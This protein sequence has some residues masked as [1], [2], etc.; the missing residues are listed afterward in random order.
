GSWLCD[1]TRRTL[2]YVTGTNGNNSQSYFTN[3]YRDYVNKTDNTPQIRYAEVLLTLAE[4][5]ARNASG[6][7]QRAIDLLNTVRNRALSAPATQQY[8]ASN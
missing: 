4:A 3:K 6:V 5:E 7:S 1:D 8:V 2:L